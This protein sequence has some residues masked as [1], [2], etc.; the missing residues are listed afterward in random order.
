MKNRLL[1]LLVL[2]TV[3]PASMIAADLVNALQVLTKDNAIHQFLLKDKPQVKFEGTNLVITSEK[4]TA[5]FALSDVIRFT[6]QPT[7][8][9]G[10]N[11]MRAD[12]EPAVNYSEDG[13]VTISQLPANATATVYTMDGRTVQQLKA[14]HAGTYRL[15]FSGLPSGVYLVKAGNTTYKITKR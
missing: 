7:D 1:S 6:Y 9:S 4:A 15:S 10:I 8:P 14:Q 5:S 11:E 12:G 2:L 3:L 13:T